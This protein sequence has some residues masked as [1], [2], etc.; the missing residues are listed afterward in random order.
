MLRR[1]LIALAVVVALAASVLGGGFFYLRSGLP[2]VAGEIAVPGLTSAVTVQRDGAGVPYITASSQSDAWFALGHVHAQDRLWQMDFQRRI[3]AGRLSEIMGA[4]TVGYDRFMRTLGLY[5][6]AEQNIAALSPEARGALDAYTAGVNAFI[7][8]RQGALPP[9]FILLRYAPEPWKPADSLVWGRMMALQLSDN[10]RH[11]LLRAR[12]A[13]R[14]TPQQLVDL[15]PFTQRREAP[16]TLASALSEEIPG[17]D[18]PLLDRLWA[19]LP[20]DLLGVGAS[21]EWVL[22][23]AHST[24]GKPILANDPHLRFGMPNLWYLARLQAPGLS[25]TGATIPGIP[26]FVLGHNG[27][28][29]W[30]LTTTHSDTQDVF[31]ERVDPTDPERYMTPNGSAPFEVRTETIVVRGEA[32]VELKLRRTR[33]GPVVTDVLGGAR[34]VAGST[35]Q[36]L[37]LAFPGLMA[38]D[39]TAEGLYRLNRAQDWKSFLEALADF[40]SPQ[41]NFAYADTDGNI[42]FAVAGRTPTRKRGDGRLPA[43]GW[44]GE[45]DW[46]G[47]LP[48]EQ[49]PRAFNPTSGIIVNANNKPGPDSVAAAL[50]S[51]W[52]PTYRARRILDLLALEPRQSIEM[53]AAMQSDA[54][55]LAARDLLGFLLQVE[56]HDDRGRRAIRQLRSWDGRM[57]RRRPEPLVFTAWLRELNRLLYADEL[58]PLFP[59]YWGFRPDVVEMMLTQRRE[60]C[61]DVSTPTRETCEDRVATA[62]DRALAWIARRHGNN[63]G[64]W[65]WGDAHQAR[66]SHPV[67]GNLWLVHRLSD[68]SLPSDG[69]AFTINRG[70]GAIG[71]DAEPFA[72]LHGAGFRAVYDLADLDNSRFMQAT[73][74]SGHPLSPHY[75]DLGR[76]W[77]D[78]RSIRIPARPE[79]G[80]REKITSLTMRPASTGAAQ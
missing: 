50:G 48:P 22:D 20:H 11:E 26:F 71:D 32:P 41:Q 9:E 13:R 70:L 49:M 36:E 78:G 31:V 7:A 52:D 40:H 77:R 72:H 23:G 15:Y 55:S 4:A 2:R 33:H 19:A 61:D 79:P 27:R 56:P 5:R 24:T 54:V 73:G 45:Y 75:A 34:E 28:I 57:D 66:F 76:R 42:G 62:L 1:L 47:F 3:G 35:G 39:R 37:S 44:S 25:L 65:R 8:N 18:Q 69:D 59:D 63:P 6:V 30:G 58:G 67:L 17:P 68:L 80:P 53:T 64:D 16:A 21:N 38:D 60:W 29:A 12:L 43:P 10:M 51:D 14:L 74:Q 46:T